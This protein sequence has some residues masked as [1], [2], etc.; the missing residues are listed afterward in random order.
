M[1]KTATELFNEYYA[2]KP[3][4]RINLT[5]Q[6]YVFNHQQERIDELEKENN[7]LRCSSISYKN[8]R[9]ANAQKLMVKSVQ[10]NSIQ[11][12][13]SVLKDRLEMSHHI[14][15]QSC[16]SASKQLKRVV[17]ALRGDQ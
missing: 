3:G 8:Q 12:E 13:L 15:T 5:V 11:A 9:D 10:Y 17:K 7:L 1:T 16:W 14:A 4:E 6:D 2:L